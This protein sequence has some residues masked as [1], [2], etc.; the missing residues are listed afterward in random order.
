MD[1]GTANTLIYVRGKG[2]LVDEPSVVAMDRD[3][4]EV[5]AVGKE[6]R[7]LSGRQGNNAVVTC[8]PL[9]DGVIH[10]F[11]TASLMIRA[12]LGKV[13][14][15]LPLSRPRLVIAVPAGITSVEKRAV[16]EAADMAGAG[17]VFLVEEPMAAAIGTGL[18]VDQPEGQMVVDIGGGTTEVAL[19]C[20]FSIAYSETL[21]IAG[22]EANDA[23]L[24]Y[25]RTEHKMGISEAMAELLK[26]KIGSAAPLGK[27]LEVKLRGKDLMEGMPKTITINDGQIREV[28]RESTLAMVDAVRR[29]LEQASPDLTSDIAENGIWLAGGGALLKGMKHLI[30]DN[31]GVEVFISEDP[32]RSVIRGAGAIIERMDYYKSVFLN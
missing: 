5:V 19:I 21:R 22:D 32:L 4:G 11:D 9:R 2:V 7:S 8:R 1:L 6:A 13:F 18:P 29:V 12:L 3:S 15:K 27:R 24:R 26:M 17:K 25:I 28:L 31:I 16:I 14:K 30:Q 23:I 10:D 20:R